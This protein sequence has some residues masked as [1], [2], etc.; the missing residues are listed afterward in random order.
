V[1]AAVP[2]SR[3]VLQE[4]AA[5][6]V[7]DS[8]S[9]FRDRFD[10]VV[11][12]TMSDWHSEPRSNRY[13]FATRFARVT[14]VLFV[15]PDHADAGYAFEESGCAGIEIL[16]VSA[17]FDL[18]Q[19]GS[20]AQALT[21]RKI[22]KPLLWIYSGDYANVID[23]LYSPY[24]IFHATEDYFSP[25]LQR[26]ISQKFFAGLTSMF[27]RIDL[28]VAVSDGVAKSY[29]Q[30]GNYNGAILRL[31][32][33]CDFAFCQWQ[34]TRADG[35]SRWRRQDKVIFYQGGINYRIDYDLVERLARSM[36]DW[37]FW[38]C[39]TRHPADAR[40]SAISRMENVWDLGQLSPEKVACKAWQASVGIIPFVQGPLIQEKSFPLKA[41]EYVACGLPVVTVP[42]RSLEKWPDLFT[43]AESAEEFEEKIRYVAPKVSDQLLL[44]QRLAA[45]AQQDYDRRFEVL[46]AGITER[47]PRPQEHLPLKIL[48]LYSANSAFTGCVMEHI[49]SF[50]RYSRH[51]VHFAHAVDG[52]DCQYDMSKFDVVI[53]HYGVRLIHKEYISSKVVEALRTCGAYKIMFIQDE[54]ENVETTRGWMD[55]I[56]FHAVFTCVP[57]QQSHLVYPANRFPS[58]ELVP[59]LTG[60]VPEELEC[61][62]SVRPLAERPIV[63]GYRGRQ[64]PFR[65]G[66]LAY[67]KFQIGS[68]MRSICEQRSISADIEW[69][70]E[71]R[72]YGPQWYEF[73]ASCRAILGTESGSNVFDED[74]SLTQAM[75]DALRHDPALTF[76]EMHRQFLA[77]RDGQ[78]R[79]NQIS[80]RMF[81]AAALRTALV[82]F[83]GEYSGVL[84]PREHYI[85][86]K[87][88]FSNVD[89]VLEQLEDVRELERMVDRTYRD[90]VRSGKYTYRA[91]VSTV[92]DFLEARI[93]SPKPWI[94]QSK[95]VGAVRTDARLEQGD[96]RSG[97]IVGSAVSWPT[98]L[99]QF[100]PA[101]DLG[102]DRP[103][104]DLGKD[105][106]ATDLG[107]RG[108]SSSLRGASLAP[109]L[110]LLRVFPTPIES[111]LKKCVTN[112]NR[113]SSRLHVRLLR[114]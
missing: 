81:E 23:I 10:A 84:Q 64:L 18:E 86:L 45:A 62:T 78:I 71:K 93:R 109:Q 59:T 95:I 1:E 67:E 90:I 49:T 80:P 27:Q 110:R 106:P 13:H 100:E 3:S 61:R 60:F 112:L 46:L 4:N 24:R 83:E 36:P 75:D 34:G 38:F 50:T 26:Q 63:I 32:N 82:L 102:K 48:V 40:W 73:I 11:M 16:H 79:M 44:A 9:A 107:K 52:V 89:W 19:A 72:I 101:T 7:E 104:T 108:W 91:F 76:E 47:R 21:E 57:D 94:L 25:E 39:G 5:A 20:I 54:Y 70:E 37:E 15:Q 87:K 28:L 51:S 111:A 31:E 58:T 103:A 88:D 77:H 41:F 30:R 56:G 96:E 2:C 85:P 105:R 14:R 114:G 53:L 69:A 74:G 68:Q 33:G 65:F 42:I 8:V 17:K 99:A 97:A 29:R 43:F 22:L 92:D 12:L 6:K 55:L 35:S 66:R 113:I 98:L